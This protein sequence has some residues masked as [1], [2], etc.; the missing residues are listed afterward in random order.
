MKNS[1]FCA[2]PRRC[3][4]GAARRRRPPAEE[5]GRA[6]ARAVAQMAEARRS[7]PN[8]VLCS[9]ALRTRETL[10]ADPAAAWRRRRSS[11]TRTGF[12]SPAPSRLLDRLRDLPDRV[13]RVLLIGHNPGL[14]ELA[15]WL[16]DGTA[17]PLADRLA[18]NL[19]T[20]ALVAV[21]GQHR[22]SALRRRAAR[23][24]AVVTPKDLEQRA[25]RPSPNSTRARQAAR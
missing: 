21:R 24:V 6:A 16:A 11:T 1:I 2:M 20:A 18:T 19:A 4:Q 7:R 23:L 3:P 17:G 15:Q 5:R 25:R 22:W 14:H 12:I 9:T 10:D 13:E 8:S